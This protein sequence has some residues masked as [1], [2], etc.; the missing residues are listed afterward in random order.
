MNKEEFLVIARAIKNFYREELSEKDL[1]EI[2][3][4][5]SATYIETLLPDPVSFKLLK[6]VERIKNGNYTV[7][8][9][10]GFVIFYKDKFWPLFMDRNMIEILSNIEAYEETLRNSSF[11][12]VLHPNSLSKSKSYLEL[13]DKYYHNKEEIIEK[14]RID[15]LK[16]K[17]NIF[18]KN[19]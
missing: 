7:K 5:T 12:N 18:N 13:L 17:K 19:R 4:S 15:I 6:D 10:M 11:A 16:E 14:R 3:N 9:V 8:D 1:I 2:I